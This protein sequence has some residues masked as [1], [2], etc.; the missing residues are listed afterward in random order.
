MEDQKLKSSLLNYLS[1]ETGYIQS[2]RHVPKNNNGSL[3]FSRG[4]FNQVNNS[5]DFEKLFHVITRGDGLVIYHWDRCGHCVRTMP[6]FKAAARRSKLP[7][8]AIEKT[9]I[10]EFLKYYQ[11]KNGPKNNV[12]NIDGYPTIM[13]Y[14]AGKLPRKYN[15]PRSEENYANEL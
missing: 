7:L 12:P 3:A 1:A 5:S 4:V 9:L 13:V 15:K 6:D 14:R 11:Q 8:I 2:T 10:P